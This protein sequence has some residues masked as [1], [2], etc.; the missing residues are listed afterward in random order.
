MNIFLP[1]IFRIVSNPLTNV[2]QKKLTLQG[3]SSLWI[4]FVSYFILSLICLVNAFFA[5]WTF[6]TKEIVLYSLCGG[7]F[8][9]LGNASLIKALS[10]GELSVLGPINS[11]KSIVALIVA[12]ILLRE[13]PSG[14]GICGIFLI[15][16]G[17]YFIFDTLEEGFS[18]KLLRR[19][20]IKYRLF[21]TVF[22]AIEAVFIK[23]VIVLSSA[24]VSFWFWCWF[25]CVFSFLLLKI[26]KTSGYK[27]FVGLKFYVGIVLCTGIMQL[28]TN[29]V[30]EN[31]NVSYALALFQLSTIISLLFGKHFF[32][33]SHFIKK[34]CGSVIMVIGAIAV[35]LG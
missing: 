6:L 8:G 21:A 14:V 18:I 7:L 5:D 17:S 9:A 30:F 20:D 2:F 22:T 13:I 19:R 35:I 1:L 32:N 27:S 23:Q 16:W 4:N 25:G 28:S 15:I 10:C 31:M 26:F 34:L 24:L 3:S 33:E 29:Y 12:F 11:Y